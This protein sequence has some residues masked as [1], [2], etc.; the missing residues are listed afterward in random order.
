MR[1]R[2]PGQGLELGVGAQRLQERADVVAH[3]GLREVELGAVVPGALA[4]GEQLQHLELPA[5]ESGDIPGDGAALLG[6]V[7][8]GGQTMPR[9]SFPMS[10]TATTRRARF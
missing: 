5:R 3:R 4:R 8:P 1:A 2:L 9:T 6:A 10:P 7:L